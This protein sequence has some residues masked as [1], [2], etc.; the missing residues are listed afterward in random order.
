M[1]HFITKQIVYEELMICLILPQIM[2]LISQKIN[3][4]EIEI[5]FA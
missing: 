2:I 3:L 4:I 1:F 5:L